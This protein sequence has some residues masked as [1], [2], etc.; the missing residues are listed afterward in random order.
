VQVLSGAGV[1]GIVHD[2]QLK[3]D[4]VQR[5]AEQ[6]NI[7][8]VADNEPMDSS[9]HRS[10]RDRF[11]LN[12]AVVAVLLA[13]TLISGHIV[14][15]NTLAKIFGFAT[16]AVG[17][18]HYVQDA[19]AALRRRRLGF[20]QL[21]VLAVIGGVALGVIEE[22]AMLVVIFSVG[23]VLEEWIADRANRSLRLLMDIV[24][25]TAHRLLEDGGQEA[26]P[27]RDL[28][29]GDR[30]LVRAGERLPTDGL[31]ISGSSA[32]DQSAVT[33]ESIPVEVAAGDDVFG[34]TVNG[35][36]ALV[37]EVARS[38]EETTLAR[39]IRQVEDAQASKGSAQRFAD[40]FGARYTP[41]VVAIALTA[42]VLGPLSGG[43]LREWTYRALVV[44]IVSCSCALAI[45]VP[46]AI[47][48]AVTR[49]AR[50]GILIRGGAFLEALAAVR[51]V[52]FDKTGTL[53]DGRPQLTDVL[54]LNGVSE[55]D[56]LALA[57]SVEAVSEHP[58]AGAVLAGARER[59]VTW[60]AAS[61][62]ETQPGVGV[63]AYADGHRLF[64][65][66][67]NALNGH[68]DSVDALRAEG[69][70]VV[71]V[72]RDDLP[73]GLLAVVDEL[74]TST[75]RTVTN[76]H[77]LG[78]NRVV[79][80]TGDHE[81]VTGAV[82]RAAGVDEWRAGLLPEDKSAEIAEL[83]R[84]AGPVAMVGDG[85]N[86]APALALADVG[87]AMGT[88]GTTVA[89][90]TA[91]V[92]LM[93][94]ELEKLPDAIYLGRRAMR[95]VRQNIVLALLTVVV[96]VGAALAGRLALAEGLLLNEV[97]AILIIANGLRLLRPHKFTAG[98]APSDGDKQ[99]TSSVAALH[100]ECA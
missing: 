69:K 99:S 59:G 8:L 33:G 37:L 91:D 38:Y 50:E 4:V 21:L 13:A 61:D 22:T 9:E 40:R 2:G 85:I 31:V 55:H 79:M 57:A 27:V 3:I 30:L 80:L 11:G 58:L 78:I 25:A 73:I 86:D 1:I 12:I 87:I 84:E 44:F 96:L 26:V 53:T 32:V 14:D 88:S 23:E 10:L 95:V 42:A 63:S 74:R 17:G 72:A 28:A 18:V 62:V 24:P 51:T 90:E 70:T 39:V 46:T 47:A 19:W 45:S 29:V 6:H 64:V 56:V 43:S 35:N 83:K 52:V 5:A 82:A 15:S 93:A 34:G 76:L 65:G 49:G 75:R 92:A 67:P 98:R 7:S 54:A 60:Q 68:L 97:A 89:L 94:N 36:G 20:V 48:A 41:T 81:R 71:V 66:R 100:P 16:I 77:A